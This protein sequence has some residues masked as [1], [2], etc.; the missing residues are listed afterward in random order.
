ME[1]T[2]PVW[3]GVRRG[4]STARRL[5]GPRRRL[6]S[7]SV[8]VCRFVLV[9]EIRDILLVGDPLFRPYL[10]RQA[11]RRGYGRRVDLPVWPRNRRRS[12][13][14]LRVGEARENRIKEQMPRCVFWHVRVWWTDHYHIPYISGTRL[15]LP[16]CTLVLHVLVQSLLAPGM[17]CKTMTLGGPTT[18]PTSA[19]WC[20]QSGA[21]WSVHAM[22]VE[23]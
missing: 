3:A 21:P 5:A 14:L 23:Q 11:N 8:L 12:R 16:I 7:G 1:G 20:L 6:E 9:I 15:S 17:C 2:L 19:P 13:R 10:P 22:Q 18:L 4:V